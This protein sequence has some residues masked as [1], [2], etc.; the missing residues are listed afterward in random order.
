[1]ILY[2]PVP[3]VVTDRTFSIRTALEA[4]TVTPGRTA[5]D[6]SLTVPA[7]EACAYAAAGVSKSP[8]IRASRWNLRIHPPSELR[9]VWKGEY[10]RVRRKS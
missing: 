8:P 1:M 5:P 7:I 6:E 2:W 10:R 4:S 9:L 3:S